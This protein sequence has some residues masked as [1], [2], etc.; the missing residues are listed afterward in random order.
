MTESQIND[1]RSDP[2]G[3]GGC[4]FCGFAGDYRLT[5]HGIY[6][7]ASYSWD[8]REAEPVAEEDAWGPEPEPEP[9]PVVE[10][11]PE[12]TPEPEAVEPTAEEPTEDSEEEAEMAPPGA[13]HATSSGPLPPSLVDTDEEE[14]TA[15]P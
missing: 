14:D 4:P 7:T 1:G 2:D 15:A 5:M 9:E 6:V 12:P 3:P 11:T 10:P 13:P 8:A